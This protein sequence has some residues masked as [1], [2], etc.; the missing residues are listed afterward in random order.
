M[1]IPGSPLWQW[2]NTESTSPG[3]SPWQYKPWKTRQRGEKRSY[4]QLPLL[5]FRRRTPGGRHSSGPPI[6]AHSVSRSWAQPSRTAPSV[7][8]FCKAH[9]GLYGKS[10]CSFAA[11]Q[12]QTVQRAWPAAGFPELHH[13]AAPAPPRA[14]NFA[15]KWFGWVAILDFGKSHPLQRDPLARG[16]ACG[17]HLDHTP[18][19]CRTLP[20]P[21]W[22]KP[23]PR[24][25][26]VPWEQA[27]QQSALAARVHTELQQG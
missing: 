8:G 24:A 3:K 2:N 15:R 27:C 7:R 26:W 12:L 19:I 9:P 25:L 23:K 1:S 16:G 21:P 22:P 18:H 17:Q 20:W 13:R 11:R 4:F 14:S 10:G 5:E 6:S